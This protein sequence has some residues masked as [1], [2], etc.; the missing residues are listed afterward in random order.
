MRTIS[1]RLPRSIHERIK[2]LAERDGTSINQFLATAAAEKVARWM[3]RNIWKLALAGEPA[4]AS[5]SSCD[6]HRMWSRSLP[7]DCHLRRHRHPPVRPGRNDVAIPERSTGSPFSS[8]GEDHR[9]PG[10]SA[11][12]TELV[13]AMQLRVSRWSRPTCSSQ[14]ARIAYGLFAAR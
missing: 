4:H 11:R 5:S 6:G 14:S 8:R 12:F 1:L 3:P 7:I 10:T 2:A 9:Y 13:T